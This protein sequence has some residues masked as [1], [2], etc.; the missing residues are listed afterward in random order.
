MAIENR[1]DECEKTI[2]FYVFY[3]YKT[4]GFVWSNAYF[5]LDT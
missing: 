4:E 3:Y 2:E 1:I 5:V